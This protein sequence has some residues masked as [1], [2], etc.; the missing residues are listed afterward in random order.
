MKNYKKSSLAVVA[1]VGVLL[2]GASVFR[3]FKSSTPGAVSSKSKVTVAIDSSDRMA[4]YDGVLASTAFDAL[5][6]VSETHSIPLVKKQYDFGVF[7]S[8]I[9]KYLNDSDKAWVYL[10]NGV[11]G[12]VAADKKII[13][14]GDYILWHYTKPTY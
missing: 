14:E 4:T 10:V 8:G 9:G 5:E 12:D 2:V 11:S 1:V 6:N 7:V 3:Y 13:K